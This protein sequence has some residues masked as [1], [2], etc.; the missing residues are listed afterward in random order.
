MSQYMPADGR[1]DKYTQWNVLWD[2]DNVPGFI[3]SQFSLKVRLRGRFVNVCP[4]MLLY[5]SLIY[6]SV[7]GLVVNS[8]W[9]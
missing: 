5:N 2:D 7:Y 4:Y 6:V 1:A 3:L 9:D 8:L